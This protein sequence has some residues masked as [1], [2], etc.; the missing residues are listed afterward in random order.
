MSNL[1]TSLNARLRS[2]IGPSS[3]LFSVLA[4][5]SSTVVSSTPK[6]PEYR[7]VARS[8]GQKVP[9]MH[10]A[11]IPAYLRIIKNREIY[12][13]DDEYRLYEKTVRDRVIYKGVWT[14]TLIAAGYTWFELFHFM[15]ENAP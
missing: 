1:V 5:R 8:T 14:I 2:G 4:S 7:K 9:R 15:R 6:E 3:P 13:R 12:Q 11:W 10:S